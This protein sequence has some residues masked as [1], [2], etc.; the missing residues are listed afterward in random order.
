MINVMLVSEDT[1][2][3]TVFGEVGPWDAWWS[4]PLP[5]C[6][7]CNGKVEWA[8]A[9][10]TPGTR[11]CA[12]CKLFYRLQSRMS[13]DHLGKT[14]ILPPFNRCI[15]CGSGMSEDRAHFEVKCRDCKRS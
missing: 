13:S 11:R 3:V 7:A 6:P 15:V 14:G 1:G 9:G 5:P 2:E 12:E 4:V 10:R 8:E